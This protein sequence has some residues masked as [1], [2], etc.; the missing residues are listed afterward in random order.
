MTKEEVIRMAREAGFEWSDQGLYTNERDG[1][2]HE[3]LERFAA[4]VTAAEREACAKVV[5]QTPWSNW[6]QSDCAAAIRARGTE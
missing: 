2:C 6:F 5:E 4:L 1:V 3:E